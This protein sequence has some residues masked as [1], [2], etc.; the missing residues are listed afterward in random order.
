M[1]NYSWNEDELDIQFNSLD[2]SEDYLVPSL[3]ITLSFLIIKDMEATDKK[4][5]KAK[6]SKRQI[7]NLLEQVSNSWEIILDS[8]EDFLQFCRWWSNASFVDCQRKD[9]GVRNKICN[10]SRIPK[11]QINSS[12][13]GLDRQFAWGR[14][15]QTSIYSKLWSG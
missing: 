9:R 8:S 10:L 6:F 5:P 3:L 1:R 12:D 13:G 7:L 11:H 4:L 14:V 15:V 2:S